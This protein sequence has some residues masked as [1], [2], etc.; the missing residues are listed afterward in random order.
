M[1]PGA[2]ARF[3]RGLPA[4]AGRPR[5]IRHDAARNLYHDERRPGACPGPWRD[6]KDRRVRRIPLRQHVFRHAVARAAARRAEGAG[7]HRIACPG[8]MRDGLTTPVGA[9]CG[10][11]L[12]T[13]PVPGPGGRGAGRSSM[14]TNAMMRLDER[15]WS[16]SI[17]PGPGPA[18]TRGNEAR[19]SSRRMAEPAGNRCR[20]SATPGRRL[21]GAAGAIG[22]SLVQPGP[23]IRHH[24][25]SVIRMIRS[26][27]ADFTDSCPSCSP[28]RP[29]FLILRAFP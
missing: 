19:A 9:V 29:E 11:V 8:R 23:S 18:R 22:V 17:G 27:V 13:R 3:P 21:R 1:P 26:G 20:R 15:D 2:Q 7:R 6:A 25:P 28:S 5:P 4:G 16:R 12:S 10:S 24:C 14:G